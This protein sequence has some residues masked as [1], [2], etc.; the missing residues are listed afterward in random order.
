MQAGL[1][2]RDLLARHRDLRLT[3]FGQDRGE[4]GGALTP[5]C[6]E[7]LRAQAIPKPVQ[8]SDSSN[9]C[10]RFDGRIRA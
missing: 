5:E 3:A 7:V 8:V 10:V 6:V 2:E 4:V 1:A 9:S